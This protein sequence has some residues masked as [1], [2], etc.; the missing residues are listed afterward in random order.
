MLF[1]F[2]I[3]LLLSIV[4]VFF[5]IQY[6]SSLGLVAIPNERSSHKKVTPCGAGIAF[7]SSVI[8][9]TL[10]YGSSIY[11]SYPLLVSAFFM[12]FGIGIY[13]DYRQ[14]A[15]Q[16]KFLVIIV[17]ALFVYIDGIGIHSLGNYF[18]HNVF[19]SWMALPV[20]LLAIVG[21][22]NA[23]N[24]SDGLDG[25]AGS[26]CLVIITG[27]GYIGWVNDNIFMI[28]VSIVL[29][30]SLLGFMWFNWNP[31]KVFMGD[32]GSL[33]LGFMIAVLSIQ[34]LAYVTPVSI[35]FIAAIPILDT[36]IVMMRR[37][38]HK[39][40]MVNADKNHLHHILLDVF[41]G[42]VKKTVLFIASVQLFFTVLGIFFI[43]HVGQEFTLPLFFG[44]LFLFYWL[45]EKVCAKVN[46]PFFVADEGRV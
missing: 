29:F 13:D 43:N 40:S 32:S 19:L 24:L 38:K 25:L 17:A 16:T 1:L 44:F 22:T 3:T 35:L 11:D 8:I 21:F 20:T 30:S 23:L 41:S 33:T 15:S 6:A 39:C 37:K 45:I 2:I 36:V 9:S 18:G 12:V 42:S 14:T 27:L 46:R 10:L 4:L 28:Y 7:F 5:L 34:A 26:I 31:A